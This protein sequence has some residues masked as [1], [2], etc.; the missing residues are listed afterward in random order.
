MSVSSGGWC[1]CGLRCGMVCVKYNSLLRVAWGDCVALSGVCVCILGVCCVLC[2]GAW[3]GLCVL[4]GVRLGVYDT[5][6][7]LYCV[8]FFYVFVFV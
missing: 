4:R 1:A 8:F 2:V 7:C 6:H 5:W 3:C